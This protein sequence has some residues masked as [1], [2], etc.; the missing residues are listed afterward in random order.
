MSFRNFQS[1]YRLLTEQDRPGAAGAATSGAASAPPEVAPSAAT[2]G[3]ATLNR[4][5]TRIRPMPLTAAQT[6]LRPLERLTQFAAAQGFTVTATTGGRHNE[7]SLHYRGR[8]VD[9]R[10]RDKSEAQILT[11]MEAAL[12]AGFGVRDERTKPGGQGVWSGAH[13][14]L[15]DTR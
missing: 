3:R 11:M 1:D 6:A 13:V 10:V 12:A 2:Y 15:Q 14:H 7:N 9:V 4:G 5:G 8:A